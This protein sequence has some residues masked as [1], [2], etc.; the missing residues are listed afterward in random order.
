MVWWKTLWVISAIK[1]SFFFAVLSDF[2]FIDTHSK[3]WLSDRTLQNAKVGESFQVEGNWVC[4]TDTDWFSKCQAVILSNKSHNHN[5][6]GSLSS[7]CWKR[8]Y[9]KKK[10]K[11]KKMFHLLSCSARVHNSE[12]FCTSVFIMIDITLIFQIPRITWLGKI[13]PQTL[14]ATERNVHNTILSVF[15]LSLSCQSTVMLTIDS[16]ANVFSPRMA[17][18]VYKTHFSLCEND[19]MQWVKT[20]KL[21]QTAVCTDNYQIY[22][23]TTIGQNHFMKSIVW[24]QGHPLLL[25]RMDNYDNTL[26]TYT[27]RML[28]I[29][30]SLKGCRLMA[31]KFFEALVHYLSPS[32]EK[33]ELPVKSMWSTRYWTGSQKYN[34]QLSE[35]GEK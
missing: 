21:S 17:V 34:V 30:S 20:T 18:R 27:D 29:T 24:R 31:E 9:L 6:R 35:F 10:R 7:S 19:R 1:N 23:L 28:S 15:E 11:K 3:F 25:D 32:S 13:S 4:K 22:L 14:D 33:R 12:D 26:H 8:R 16:C 2:L 5:R